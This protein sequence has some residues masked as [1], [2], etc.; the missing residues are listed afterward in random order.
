MELLKTLVAVLR[1]FLASQS[2]L[3]LENLALRQQAVG[4][5]RVGGLHHRYGRAA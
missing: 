3:A 2:A 1:A 4:L 5:P